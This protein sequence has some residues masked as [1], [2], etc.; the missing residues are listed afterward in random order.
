MEKEILQFAEAFGLTGISGLGLFIVWK[1]VIPWSNVALAKVS[2]RDQSLEAEINKIK[3]N[4]LH[5]LEEWKTR[6]EKLEE[7]ITIIENNV[8]DFDMFKQICLDAQKDSQ[9]KFNE[10]GER[11]ARLEERTK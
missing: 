5:E 6:L 7:R 1:I 11:L 2:G 10:I 9:E 8:S 4:E 3:N